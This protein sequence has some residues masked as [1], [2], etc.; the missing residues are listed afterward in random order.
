MGTLPSGATLIIDRL[1]AETDLLI[2]EGVIE[3]H[4]FAGF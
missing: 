4:F 3:L 2:V 1:A